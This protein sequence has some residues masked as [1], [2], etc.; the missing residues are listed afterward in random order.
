MS[1]Y[2]YSRWD[3]SQRVFQLDEGGLLEALADDILSHGDV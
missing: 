1:A 2:K 3:G